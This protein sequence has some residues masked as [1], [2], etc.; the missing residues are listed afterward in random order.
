MAQ[1]ISEDSDQTARMRRLICVFAGRISL[2]VSFFHALAHT[3][4]RL[5]YM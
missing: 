2:I 5:F 3:I 4:S 1:A